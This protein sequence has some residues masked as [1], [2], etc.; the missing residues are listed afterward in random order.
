MPS[1]C[2]ITPASRSTARRQLD[3]NI[4]VPLGATHVNVDASRHAHQWIPSGRRRTEQGSR[5]RLIEGRSGGAPADDLGQRRAW[6]NSW[7]AVAD[8]M[9]PAMPWLRSYCCGWNCQKRPYAASAEFLEQSPSGGICL[10]ARS[11]AQLLSLSCR[12]QVASTPTATY[13]WLG[14]MT[15]RRVT[16]IALLPEQTPLFSPHPICHHGNLNRANPTL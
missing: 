7:T 2:W 15:F 11:S 9:L 13:C 10:S 8:G 14:I 6:R 3:I 16:S 5:G 1:R 12:V 4:P